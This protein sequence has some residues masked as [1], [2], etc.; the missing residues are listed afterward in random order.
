MISQLL[1]LAVLPGA[2]GF[3]AYPRLTS[4]PISWLL[5]FGAAAALAAL[6]AATVQFWWLSERSEL[7]VAVSGVVVAAAMAALSGIMLIAGFVGLF[8]GADPV[9]PRPLNRIIAAATTGIVALLLC[10]RLIVIQAGLG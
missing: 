4:R 10:R 5:A 3:A 8:G 2:I 9:T 7:N 6:M 1:I